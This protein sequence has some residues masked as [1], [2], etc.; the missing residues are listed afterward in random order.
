MLFSLIRPESMGTVP[1]STFN[2]RLA[3]P[4]H[5]LAAQDVLRFVLDMQKDIG[6]DPS[7]DTVREFLWITLKSGRVIPGYGHGVL[8]KPV[9]PFSIPLS[10]VRIRDSEH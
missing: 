6:M 10:E 2:V 8:R 9:C 5:G 1:S 3:G 7:D 4:L